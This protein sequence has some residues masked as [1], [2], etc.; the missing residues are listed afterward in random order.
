M[1]SYGKFERGKV[2]ILNLASLGFLVFALAAITYVA[3]NPEIRQLVASQAR[4]SPDALIRQRE[5]QGGCRGAGCLAPEI[6]RN[7]N[8]PNNQVGEAAEIIA[9]YDRALAGD[10]GALAELQQKNEGLA[11]EIEESLKTQ[12]EEAQ[13]QEQER[14]A[15]EKR[16]G[17]LRA[18]DARDAQNAAITA[19]DEAT[20]DKALQELGSLT[21]QGFLRK[22][23]PRSTNRQNPMR[24]ISAILPLKE[25][26]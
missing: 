6:I 11:R 5:R 12:A 7:R 15:H 2:N 21:S 26:L 10:R 23:F 9:A 18:K 24:L 16:L 1:L 25:N 8:N 14:I 19:G 17:E 3:S 20:R 22:N 13:K 4:Y